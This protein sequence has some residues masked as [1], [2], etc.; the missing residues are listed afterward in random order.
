MMTGPHVDQYPPRAIPD[1]QMQ[2]TVM[3]SQRHTLPSDHGDLPNPRPGAS[4]SAS[5]TAMS[6]GDVLLPQITA[7]KPQ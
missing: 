5:G 1:G 2:A 7:I 4:R 6:A 3:Q